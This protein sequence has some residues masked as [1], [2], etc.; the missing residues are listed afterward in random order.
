[1]GIIVFSYEDLILF[2][3][4]VELLILLYRVFNA[5]FNG[6]NRLKIGLMDTEL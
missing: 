2:V 4:I 3:L 1:M 6:E 5:A